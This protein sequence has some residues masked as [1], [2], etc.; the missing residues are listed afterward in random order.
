MIF[1]VVDADDMLTWSVF[2]GFIFIWYLTITPLGLIGAVHDMSR[3]IS[4]GFNT[5]FTLV[6]GPGSVQIQE[7]VDQSSSNNDNNNNNSVNNNN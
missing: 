2:P 4:S 7:S 5:H 6:G 1:F 3:E